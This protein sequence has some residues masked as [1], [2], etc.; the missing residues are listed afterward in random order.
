MGFKIGIELEGC[1]NGEVLR[2]IH[3]KL[4]KYFDVV[5]DGSLRNSYI[6]PTELKRE[7]ITHVKKDKKGFFNSLKYLRDLS[8]CELKDFVDFNSSTGTHVHFEFDNIKFKN[9]EIKR[10]YALRRRFF[11]KLNDS[12]INSKQLIKNHY[13]RDYAKEINKNSSWYNQKYSEFNLVSEVRNKGFEW[14]S[15]NLLG[16]KTWKEFFEFFEIVYN[17]L[18]WFNK[19]LNKSYNTII[20][21]EVTLNDN[22]EIEILKKLDYIEG[23]G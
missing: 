20:C 17:C 9:V 5:M 23:S 21:F 4:N 10:L 7:L 6:F 15:L 8:N 13:F 16:V 18:I 19:Y 11:K 14:R 12:S 1:Y 22:I 3:P 2:E